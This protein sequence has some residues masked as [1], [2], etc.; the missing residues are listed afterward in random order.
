MI[1]GDK[2]F[3]EETGQIRF[4]TVNID[5][6]NGSTNHDMRGP[7]NQVDKPH[8]S[9]EWFWF[10]RYPEIGPEKLYVENT[11]WDCDEPF[12]DWQYNNIIPFEPS[13]KEIEMGESYDCTKCRRRYATIEY[14]KE[15][16]T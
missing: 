7:D 2:Q 10:T 9:G 8:C 4:C 5:G 14:R 13:A 1:C 16:T 6:P 11:C 3:I 15:Y 12:P